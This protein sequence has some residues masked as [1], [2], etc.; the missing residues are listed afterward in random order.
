MRSW[1]AVISSIAVAGQSMPSFWLGML[2][3]EFF[4]LQLHWL[5]TSGYGDLAHL[6]LPAITLATISGLLRWCVS[7]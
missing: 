3:I 5:P 2:L 4:A 7:G 1:R 6:V